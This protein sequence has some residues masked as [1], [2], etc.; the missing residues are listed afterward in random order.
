ML[1]RV[2]YDRNRNDLFDAGEG[3]RGLN[4]YFVGKDAR[5]IA[6]GSLVTEDNGT[7]RTTLPR[8]EQRIMIPYL[9]IDM[10][11]TRFPERELHSIWLSRATLPERVP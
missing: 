7:G 5:G 2:F 9:G 8:S 4:V 1:F 10:P 11:L 6:L 3:I